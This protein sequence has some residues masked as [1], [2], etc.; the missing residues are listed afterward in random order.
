VGS[1]RLGKEETMFQTIADFI[2][3]ASVALLICVPLAIWKLVDIVIWIVSHVRIHV[4]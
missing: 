4:G 1:S 3:F 2:R